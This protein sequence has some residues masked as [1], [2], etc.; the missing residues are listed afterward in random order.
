M[1]EIFLKLTQTHKTLLII[2]L[3]TFITVLILLVKNVSEEAQYNKA[4]LYNTAIQAK[5]A[6]AFNYAVDSQQGNVLTEAI[7]ST[8]EPIIRPE[9]KGS[10]FEITKTEERYTKH[11]RT[12][13]CGTEKEPQT[14]TETYYSWD[15]NGAEQNKA[16]EIVLH[17]RTYPSYL[18][19]VPYSRQLGC[20]ELN[21]TICKNG[22]EFA[23]NNW[24]ASV[25]DKRW[26]YTVTDTTFAGTI[27]I[28]TAGGYINPI[29]SN[30]IQIKQQN[31]AELIENA[32]KTTNTTFLVIILMIINIGFC[33]GLFKATT[34]QL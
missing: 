25:G 19:Y 14:C 31:I 34:N 7:F 24:L 9:T 2:L 21:V 5:T 22:F 32:N 29:K 12:Y 17:E 27:F 33:I 10:F 20:D 16:K 23:N 15:Y 6:N 4:K 28:N 18:F 26:Y 1:Q 8:V 30:T 13:Q 3:F 11:T